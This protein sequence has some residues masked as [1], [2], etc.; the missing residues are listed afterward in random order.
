[1]SANNSI[2]QLL[3]Q[4]LELNT[5]SLETFER[6]NEAISTDKDTVSINL[7][8]NATSEMKTIQIPA[9]GFLKR[10]I[11]RLDTNLKHISGI[12]ASSANIKLKD[13]SYRRLH[14]AKL[15]GP[16][17]S[18][19]SLS[20]PRKFNTKLND[21]F[22][23]FLNPLLTIN[24]DVNGQIPAD[25]ERCFIER[26]IIDSSD[27]KST[28]YFDDNLKG[29]SDL[30]HNTLISN[31]KG[32]AIKYRID[33]NV[34]DMPIRSV[35]YNGRFDVIS[36]NNSQVTKI[37]DGVSV[38][39]SVKLFTLNKLTYSDSSKVMKDTEVLKVG[40]SLVITDG[41]STRYKI[42]SIDGSKSQVELLLIEGYSA[43]KVGSKSLGIYKDIDNNLEVEINIGYNERQ[44]TFIKPIDPMSKIAA[45]DYSPGV[46]F[47]SNELSLVLDD[48]ET[49]SLASY[50]KDNVA[51]FGQFIKALKVD[52]IPPA[53]VGLKPSEPQLIED[54]F[55]VVQINKHLT[56]NSTTKKIEKLKSNKLTAEQSIKKIDKAIVNKKSMLATKK[57]ASK[58]DKD[59]QHSELSSLVA[60]RDT[61]SNLFSSIVTE[62]KATSESTQISTVKPKFRVRGFWSVPDAKEYG[63]EISQDVVQ[64][65]VRY[66]YLSTD[67]KTSTIEQISFDDTLNGVKKT[68]AFSN[69]VELKSPVKKRKFSSTLGKFQWKRDNEEDAQAINFNSLDIPITAGE[70][71][72][73]MVKSL[74]EAGFPT[75]PIESEWS[76]IIKV[77][78]PEE[79]T[80]DS[81]TGTV[82]E[83]ILDAVKID[84]KNELESRG[85]YSH[86]VDSFDSNDKHFSHTTTS[87]ASGF[88]SS[89]QNPISLYD[90]LIEMQ[91]EI[92]ALKEA[93]TNAIGKL[94][95][96]IVDENG[97]VTAVQ[98][99]SVAK[100][101]AGYYVDEIP[102][103][104]HKGFIVTKNFK[105][106]LSNTK[107]TN[108]ELAS[109]I[110]GNTEN[111]VY[112]SN[113]TTSF[114]NGDT[115]DA[116]VANNSYYTTTGQYDMVPVSY[117]NPELTVMGLYSGVNSPLL[118]ST[119]MKGQFIYSRFMDVSHSEPLYMT[120]D[121]NTSVLDDSDTI[122]GYDMFEYG[123]GY[124][125]SGVVENEEIPGVDWS[126]AIAGDE[127][128]S[129][130]LSSAFIWNG[131]STNSSGKTDISN[132]PLYDD[133]ILIHKDHPILQDTLDV[134][135]M[136]SGGRIG[137]P[138]CATLDSTKLN[139]KKQ[140][141]FREND[142]ISSNNV[143]GEPYNNILSGGRNTQKI[144]FSNEDRYLLGGRSCGSFLYMSPI[145]S[146]SLSV[147]GNNIFGSKTLE[148]GNEGIISIDLVFQYRMTD[149][150]GI[151]SEGNGKIGGKYSSTLDNITYAKKVGFDIID[152]S[153]T[154]FMFDVEVYSKYKASG[155]SINTI[156]A[157]MLSNYG[158]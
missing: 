113:N 76:D 45:E 114:G 67:G 145:D 12:D 105:I 65:I 124:S 22:E 5:N 18:I 112:S 91:M 49:V 94:S 88:L 8:D 19:T 25:T 81:A 97:N 30:S 149:Y 158:L 104:D 56:N 107:A 20:S 156:N 84:I 129:T 70:S 63:E 52:Y 42:L 6:I 118:Q 2:S 74:S 53:A 3:E 127:F 95:I 117:Q 40:D 69:W 64:F 141:A 75:N 134:I 51:D 62:I 92:T 150:F 146:T 157:S 144:S 87:I 57:F 35:Q 9:F 135:E 10:E 119:Q 1:M 44:I 90:K 136:V 27:L 116:S 72:E 4:F 17:K 79:F 21:F 130:G 78:F 55:K 39:K 58:V 50:Y 115:I 151:G 128:T 140:N 41:Y 86:V 14:T 37:V 38:I 34:I 36:V 15:K 26:V 126:G 98:N 108:L 43:I 99:N 11:E 154:N 132:V 59:N 71:V 142:S 138:K 33:S 106:Q 121:I 143:N 148:F 54:N 133:S 23:D 29:Q 89:E 100:I 120:D 82:E 60:K 155:N 137:M 48:G 24:L 131:S 7:Y 109:R 77:E 123:L 68:G 80:I 47:F 101:F 83:N 28:D 122:T 31:L 152:A 66:R 13:G 153:G 61:E 103:T 32:E 125:I 96:S 16:S 73:I 147:N 110:I 93:A 46:A 102:S 139:Y 111:P 85:I